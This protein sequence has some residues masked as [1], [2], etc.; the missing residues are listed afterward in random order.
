MPVRCPGE[1]PLLS[2][3]FDFLRKTQFS[4]LS[5]LQVWCSH[6]PDALFCLVSQLLSCP[7]EG[8]VL[9]LLSPQC[10]CFLCSPC[11][12]MRSAVTLAPNPTTAASDVVTSVLNACTRLLFTSSSQPYHTVIFHFQIHNRV[13]ASHLSFMLYQDPGRNQT[14]FI[15]FRGPQ[16]IILIFFFLHIFNCIISIL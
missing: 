1:S 5:K 15:R 12:D 11:K 10:S 4:A 9:L 16:P 2:L 14:G 3:S 6:F 13:L 8:P 7:G